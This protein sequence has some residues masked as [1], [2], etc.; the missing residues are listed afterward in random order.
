MKGFYLQGAGWDK[1]NAVLIEASSVQLV[2]N[3]PTIQFKPVESKKK[4][5]DA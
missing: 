5:R 1:K 2:V 4:G 3:M